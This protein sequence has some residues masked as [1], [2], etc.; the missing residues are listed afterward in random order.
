M[1]VFCL[2]YAMDWK[3]MTKKS[4]R[5]VSYLSQFQFSL[6][7]LII[8]LRGNVGQCPRLWSRMV[9]RHI[10]RVLTRSHHRQ[11]HAARPFQDHCADFHR[12]CVWTALR[13]YRFQVHLGAYQK[14]Q[15]SS[16]CGS[17][18][19]SIHLRGIDVHAQREGC[20]LSSLRMPLF[21]C[22]NDSS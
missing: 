8:R 20:W 10:Q 16:L 17:E 7:F 19:P 14:C 3:M 15:F 22:F 13:T 18:Q 6:L 9:H 4:L 5:Q 11:R 21:L 1:N 2:D 12:S